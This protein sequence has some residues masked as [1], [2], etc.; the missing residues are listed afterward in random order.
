M[1]SNSSALIVPPPTAAPAASAETN[2]IRGIRPAE[3]IGGELL[4]LWIGLVLVALA[5]SAFLFWNHRRRKRLAKRLA[6]LIPPH[7]RAKERLQR[8]LSLIS[9]PRLFCIEVSDALRIYLEDRFSF[10]APERTTEEF[11]DELKATEHLLPDQK[12]SLGDFLQR[13][14]LV[15][16]ARHE[17]PEVE[18]RQIYEAALRLID[19]TQYEPAEGVPAS[20]NAK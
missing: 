15:K 16:F 18:L 11:L 7:V 10:K 4:W 17:P 3:E 12:L 2:D 14:D 5:V 20:S 1:A 13:C 19:E 8:A 9:E 6:P